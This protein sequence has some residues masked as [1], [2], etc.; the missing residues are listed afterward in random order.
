MNPC[1]WNKN[2]QCRNMQ[3]D[4][5]LLVDVT[6][7]KNALVRTSNLNTQ[8]MQYKGSSG[9]LAQKQIRPNKKIVQEKKITFG[10]KK[11]HVPYSSATIKDFIINP[12]F[13]FCCTSLLASRVLRYRDIDNLQTTQAQRYSL[14]S[15]EKNIHVYGY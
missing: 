2:I 10:S 15:H 9:K 13:A 8:N 11:E 14:L 7:V 12:V 6:K 5:K 1:I 3:G 4:N